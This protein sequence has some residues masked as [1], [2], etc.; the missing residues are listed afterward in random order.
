[1]K[2][3]DK[4]FIIFLFILMG[5]IYKNLKK[6]L[7]S[8]KSGNYGIWIKCEYCR[9]NVTK[10]IYDLHLEYNCEKFNKNNDI[11]NIDEDINKIINKNKKEKNVN[12]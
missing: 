10:I 2:N 5:L 11:D 8:W 3:R 6:I 7:Y 1:M 9:E 4:I 12:E